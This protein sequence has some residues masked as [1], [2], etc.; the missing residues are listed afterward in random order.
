MDTLEMLFKMEP[1]HLF[2]T[3][4]LKAEGKKKI[5]AAPGVIDN[6]C[7]ARPL[8]KHCKWIGMN[9]NDRKF[10]K[11]KSIEELAKYAVFLD[12]EDTDR[13]FLASGWVGY[14][15]P[16]YYY[17]YVRA[18]REKTDLEIYGLFGSVGKE[19]LKKL[20]DSGMDGYLCGIESPNE[21]VYKAFR[22]GGDTLSSRIES[23][24][25]TKELGLKL[26]T[27]FLYGLGEKDKDVKKALHLF[28]EL[29]PDSVSILPFEPYPHTEM[30]RC[31]PPNLYD[32][33]RI[34]AI[35]GIFLNNVNMFTVSGSGSTYCYG[36][37]AG[38]NGFYFFP[39]KRPF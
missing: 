23:L 25:A 30:E 13:I 19:S 24:H 20:K 7:L 11:R 38:T 28:K 9:G 5:L 32:W 26:W 35:A 2:Q 16:D 12:K 3:A 33:S 34:V 14:E 27:G 15:L 1:D 6:K 36:L 21:E 31:N 10:L 18:V 4:K 22:P 29:A 8:C 37:R 39:K 17:D